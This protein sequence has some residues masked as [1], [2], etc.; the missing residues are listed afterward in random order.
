[1]PSIRFFCV[2]HAFSRKPLFVLILCSQYNLY[3]VLSAG[4]I[5]D[6]SG[7]NSYTAQLNNNGQHCTI[8]VVQLRRQIFR[9]IAG[10]AQAI[11]C[12]LPSI[13]GRYDGKD[14]SK[15]AT[16]ALAANCAVLPKNVRV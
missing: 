14:A 13:F 10:K 16:K 4:C 12:V 15:C 8:I 5:A 6:F 3:R 2:W 7:N 11:L 1:M 9:Q